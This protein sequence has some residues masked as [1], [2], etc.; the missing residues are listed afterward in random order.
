MIWWSNGLVVK[1][2]DSRKC[3]GLKNTGWLH[4][5]LSL[6]S[7]R[8][9]NPTIKRA[10][11]LFFIKILYVQ[12]MTIAKRLCLW[13]LQQLQN[14][15]LVF[16]P[17]RWIRNLDWELNHVTYYL[18]W[19]YRLLLHPPNHW[20]IAQLIYRTRVISQCNFKY[21]IC[22]WEVHNIYHKMQ[23]TWNRMLI[24]MWINLI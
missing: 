21:T 10:M 8:Q 9:L 2:L 15:L 5:R 17:S 11:K 24:L 14:W 12:L 13:L 19:N 3:P 7:L 6:S 1:T 18:L 16:I 22:P 4:G 23:L 20:A